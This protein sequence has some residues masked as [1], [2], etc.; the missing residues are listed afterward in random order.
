MVNKDSHHTP[1]LITASVTSKAQ[2]TLPKPVR[3]LLKVGAKGDLVGFIVDAEAGTVRLTR[4]ETLPVDP[5]FSPGAYEKLARLRRE[6]KGK[7]FRRVSALLKDLK[8]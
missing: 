3:E 5:D 1:R 4:T 2:I 6:G 7:T 8:R